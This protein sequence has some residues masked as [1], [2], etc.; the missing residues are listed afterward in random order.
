MTKID[1]IALKIEKEKQTIVDYV[2]R[3]IQRKA[4]KKEKERK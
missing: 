2:T 3:I 4:C 1:S